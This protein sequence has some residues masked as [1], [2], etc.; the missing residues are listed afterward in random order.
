M[1][2]PKNEGKN[3][4]SKQNRSMTADGTYTTDSNV[5]NDR[6]RKE[7][8]CE[9]VVKRRRKGHDSD[10]LHTTLKLITFLHSDDGT[11]NPV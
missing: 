2:V 8:M 7:G 4:K 1:N 5:S 11:S 3:S 9:V 6:R 10:V